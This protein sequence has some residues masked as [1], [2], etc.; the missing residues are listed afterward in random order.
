MYL[1]SASFSGWLD[2][3]SSLSFYLHPSLF[4]HHANNFGQDVEWGEEEEKTKGVERESLPY[5]R[6]GASSLV[7]GLFVGRRAVTDTHPLL[8]PFHQA[9]DRQTA[10]RDPDLLSSPSPS[11]PFHLH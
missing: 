11:P 10:T 7:C 2:F 8:P 6:D 3:P 5:R 4:W 1:E 9:K